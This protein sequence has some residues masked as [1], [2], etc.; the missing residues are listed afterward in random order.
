MIGR[1]E[2]AYGAGLVAGA[3]AHADDV[4]EE[5]L[6]VELGVLRIRCVRGLNADDAVQGEVAEWRH[7]ALWHMT[8]HAAAEHEPSVAEFLQ[9][10]GAKDVLLWLLG[11][12][13]LVGYP[14]CLPTRDVVVE[15]VEPLQT[16]ERWHAVEVDDGL[17]VAV[18]NGEFVLQAAHEATLEKVKVYEALKLY[19][20]FITFTTSTVGSIFW[21]IAS[22][23][24]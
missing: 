3:L 1:G 19:I 17:A 8:G 20:G 22:M 13:R 12:E 14:Q 18:G 11:G 4:V 16:I 5:V 6:R 7:S 24:L 2:E 23:G 10:I 9:E 15:R 21:R